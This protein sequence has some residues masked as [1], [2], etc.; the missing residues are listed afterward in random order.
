MRR[1]LLCPP[2]YY[3]IE[4]EINPW[5]RRTRNAEPGLASVQWKALCDTL[6]TLGCQI[7][8]LAPQPGLPDL[9]FTANA[10]LVIGRRFILSSFR[11][12]ERRG[13]EGH[14]ER[15][16]AEHGFEVVKLPPKLIF[17]GEGDGLFCG[18]VLFCGYRFRSDIQSHLFLTELLHNLVV[19]VELVSPKKVGAFVVA[20]G[21]D[22]DGEL[23]VLTNGRNL[24]T[25]STGKVY[26][27]VPM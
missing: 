8:L 5:M 15:W 12:K 25:G 16:F 24:I 1:L 18:D 22:A 26:K 27:L 6:R 23:Y 21:Q 3:G 14:F 2:D 13:E 17:E 10:G 20:F 19:S 4:Y 7:D 11:H 9:V